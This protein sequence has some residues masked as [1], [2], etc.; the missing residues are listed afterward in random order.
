MTDSVSGHEYLSQFLLCIF[1][2][3]R[4]KKDTP[5]QHPIISRDPLGRLYSKL[6]I[7]PIEQMEFQIKHH[8]HADCSHRTTHEHL[9]I[10]GSSTIGGDS[11]LLLSR[12]MPE[13]EFGLLCFPTGQDFVDELRGRRFVFE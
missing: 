2:L 13:V 1:L 6:K 12:N 9:K 4:N 10:R 3:T 7:N 5:P 11:L 8:C